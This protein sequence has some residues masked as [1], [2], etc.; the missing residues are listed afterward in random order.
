MGDRIE[1]QDE[2]GNVTG[3]LAEEEDYSGSTW[4]HEE[5]PAAGGMV[6]IFVGLIGIGFTIFWSVIAAGAAWLL[7]SL[8]GAFWGGANPDVVAAISILAGVGTF[9]GI[10]YAT[11]KDVTW[12][13]FVEYWYYIWR[14]IRAIL[15]F[16]G[17]FR[18]FRV[19]SH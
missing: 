5:A 1:I 13:G 11:L 8:A 3:Y 2:D 19:I 6:N 14:L 17:S 18:D 12:K 15:L 4:S 16:V 9:I 10:A 7:L